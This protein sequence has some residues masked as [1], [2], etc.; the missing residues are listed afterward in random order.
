MP[1]KSVGIR[2]STVCHSITGQHA[3]VAW[4]DETG[5]NPT[6]CESA[7]RRVVIEGV[8]PAI[9][10]GRFA[11][12]RI[13][14]DVFVVEADIFA[15]GH[16]ELTS[17][18]LYR[19]EAD[20]EYEET[21]MHSL[22][23]DRWRGEFLLGEVGQ[24]RYTIEGW[25]DP[26]RTWRHDLVRRLEV[27]QDVDAELLIGASLI[28]Q[29]ASRA[30]GVAVKRLSKRARQLRS[31]DIDSRIAAALDEELE[32][33]VGRV[34]DLRFATRYPRELSIVVDR[35][36]ARFSSWYEL[37]PRSWAREPG[38]HGTF[39]DCEAWLPYVAGMGFDV[40]Y[41]PPI[42][43]IGRV[44]R[45]GR[46][47]A[48][49]ADE[50]DV[51]SPWAIGSADGGHT[52]IDPELGTLD[53]FRSLVTRAAKF[54][55]EI[56]LDLAFQ[57]A[58]DHPYTRTHREWFR[59]RPD[60]TIQYAENPPKKYQDIY[61]LNFETDN[62]EALW[63]E[64]KRVIL[65]W[66]DQ[67]VKLFRVDNPHTK[68][69]AFWEWVIAEVK[70]Q[71]PDVL[72]LSEAFTR[73]R[74]MERLAKVGFSQSYTYFAWRNTRAELEQYFRELATIGDFFRPNLWPNTPDILTAFLQVGGRPA[75]MIRGILAA[76]LGANYGIYGPA[77]ELCENTPRGPGSEEYL[78]SE[79]YEIKQRDLNAPWNLGGLLSRL[80]RIRREQRA[81]QSDRTLR[82]HPTDNPFLI[83]YSKTS[84]DKSNV[85][86][87]IVNLSPFHTH[88]G[89]VTLELDALG[90]EPARSYQ[91]HDL[92]SNDVYTWHDA[93]NYVELNPTRMP[94]HIFRIER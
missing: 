92:L 75:F 83:C 25:V 40:L 79:K 34:P 1:K 33:L 30:Q 49:A 13:V 71:D 9:D 46:N 58:P 93:R 68:P 69:F 41:L 80:N 37:F 26:F 62:W 15:D 19:R 21:A 27:R 81:L 3:A 2:S 55:L 29:A 63:L 32:V 77:F 56:A 44:F 59:E 43:P 23:N 86:L 11:V 88:A 61:P 16:T 67:G 94:A 52:E 70:S 45:K 20:A 38:R 89:W 4:R 87:T 51:G 90:I 22:G 14:G 72:F 6:D 42:H 78:D 17:R 53:D 76:T 73:P 47:N 91:V 12:K 64:L 65:F 8:S 50:H 74:V 85:I 24:Y 60:G 5:M 28:E 35:E 54:D 48:V 36:K 31:G 84:G 7:R 66:V 82:F 18:L 39:R 57:C 10:A